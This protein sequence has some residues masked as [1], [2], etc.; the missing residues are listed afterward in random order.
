MEINAAVLALSGLAQENRLEIFKMLV[1]KGPEGIPAG[2]IGERLEIPPSTLSFHLGQLKHAGL[3]D[4][5]RESRTL[6]YSANYS[7]MNGLMSYLTENCC[8][9]NTENCKTSVD[10]SLE[11]IGK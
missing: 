11:K 3:I 2:Q 10:C 9:G 4:C 6:F 8:E 5:R 1:Q 7:F